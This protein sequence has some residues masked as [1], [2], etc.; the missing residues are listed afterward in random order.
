MSIGSELMFSGIGFMF[1][2]IGLH[3]LLF[4]EFV[5][6]IKIESSHKQE[7]MKVKQ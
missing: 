4:S 1:F 3:I 7:D 5:L 6:R 2:M